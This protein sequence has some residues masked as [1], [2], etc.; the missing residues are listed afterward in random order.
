LI[1]KGEKVRI[2]SCCSRVYDSEGCSHGPHVFYESKVE[3]LHSRHPF[4]LLAPESSSTSVLDVVALDCEM[5][6]TTGGFRVARVSIVDGSGKEVFD[7][8]VR[9]DD[10]VHVMSVLL[11]FLPFPWILKEIH[12]D[13]NTRFSGITKENY[14]TAL[15][16]LASIREALNTYLDSNTILIGHALENDLKT[17]RILHHKCIDTALLFPHRAGAP[18]RRALKDV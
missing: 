1:Q 13:F 10:G 8:L 12:R 16:P 2:Y 3:E 6:Y 17:L 4:S 18:Y 14:A 9:M 7:Q 5:I 11:V 15:L